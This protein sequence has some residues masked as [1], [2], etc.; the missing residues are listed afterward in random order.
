MSKTCRVIINQVK[1]KLHLVGYL[2]IRYYKDAR[3]H[4]HKKTLT[5]KFKVIYIKKCQKT[6]IHVWNIL[7]SY[8]IPL[9]GTENEK[10]AKYHAAILKPRMML[11][12]NLTF[13]AVHS[14]HNGHAI[15]KE[16]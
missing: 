13:I 9:D 7:I 15:H 1:Q 12:L 6:I 2:L 8:F 11:S 5:T 3:Y 10:I 16:Q 4:E 14:T